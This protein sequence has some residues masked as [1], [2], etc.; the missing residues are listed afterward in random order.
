MKHCYFSCAFIALIAFFAGQSSK[1]YAQSPVLPDG[2]EILTPEGV[3]LTTNSDRVI[4]DK[5]KNLVI[6][7]SKQK[8]YK[9]YFTATDSE[10]GEELWVSDGTKEGTHMVKDLFEG[11]IS[12][13]VKYITRFNDRVVFSAIQN[14]DDGAQLF[15]SDG[16]ESG[17]H[18]VKLINEIGPAEPCGFVQLNETQFVFAAIDLE[19][20]VYGDD[21]QRWLWISDGTEEGTQLLKDCWVKYPGSKSGSDVS[22]FCRVG[23]KVFFKA[24][25]KDGEYSETLWV[26]DG[27]EEGTIMLTDIQQQV[28]DETT[29]QTGAAGIDW[30]TNVNNKWLFFEAISLD[31]REPWASDGTPEGTHMIKDITPGEAANG[32][33]KGV[34]AFT[35]CVMGDYLYYRGEDPDL[36]CGVELIRTDGTE[37][38]TTMVYDCNK[39]PNATGTN[40]GNPDIFPFCVWQDLLWGKAQWGVNESYDF[41]R[42]LELFCSDGTPEGTYMH[43]D[44]NPGVGANAA[45]EGTIV[46]GSMFFRAQDKVPVGTQTWELFRLDNTEE[47]PELVVDLAEGIDFVHSLRNLDGDLVFTSKAVPRLFRYHYRKPNYVAGKEDP[48]MD[49]DFEGPSNVYGEP[50]GITLRGKDIGQKGEI[51]IH[52]VEGALHIKADGITGY[53]VSDLAGR[54]IA[55]VAHS[56]NEVFVNTRHL[57]KGIYAVKVTTRNNKPVTTKIII[58]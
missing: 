56:G 16:T 53:Q 5:D 36:V 21:A 15:I 47:F 3:E 42:G 2:M 34:G 12:S 18:M 52:R 48:R 20:A 45:W 4:F 44:L 11:P 57:P 22:H 25:T 51:A 10:H 46:S 54:T 7:G 23:R 9:V 17:T 31:G 37:E 14:E 8:G 24:D 26:T 39:V 43:S 32:S 19:S 33:P 41:C 40:S 6:A 55:T 1:T 29:G 28:V 38:G 49:I 30:M 13:D 50:T 35:T 27:T 58:E